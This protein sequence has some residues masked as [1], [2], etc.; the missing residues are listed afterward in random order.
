MTD[1]ELR[2]EL[3]TLLTAGHETSATGLAWAFERILRRRDVVLS[4]SVA[5][6]PSAP[7]CMQTPV[8]ACNIAVEWVDEA[9]VFPIFQFIACNQPCSEARSSPRNKPKQSTS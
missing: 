9:R 6:P 3:I 7:C 5:E 4:T 8:I 1:E 2:D